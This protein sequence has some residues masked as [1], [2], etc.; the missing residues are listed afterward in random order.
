MHF[1]KLSLYFIYAFTPNTF[2]FRNPKSGSP[3]TSYTPCT[4]N[5]WPNFNEYVVVVEEKEW[6]ENNI[7]E[8]IKLIEQHEQ[9]W[10]PVIEELETINI[11]DDHV[12]ELKIETLITPEEIAE[13]IALLQKY[14]DVFVWSY[15]NMLGLDTNIKVH[16]IPLVEGCRP[17]KQKLRRIHSNIL[18][19]VK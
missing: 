15:E 10:K 6:D 7:K 17:V 2:Y 4:E 3:I 16:R 19:K 14:I 11:G 9:A 12:K 13:I 1:P 8:F 18:I 5:E